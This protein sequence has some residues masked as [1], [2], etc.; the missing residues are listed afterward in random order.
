MRD[1]I[2]GFCHSRTS[3]CSP[4]FS[5]KEQNCISLKIIQVF[6]ANFKITFKPM[7]IIWYQKSKLCTW[8][9]VESPLFYA[10]GAS[11]SLL[12]LFEMRRVWCVSWRSFH[13]ARFTLGSWH[14][15]RRGGRGWC[16]GFPFFA[17]LNRQKWRMD[18]C[19]SQYLT[20]WRFFFQLCL[21]LHEVLL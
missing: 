21:G 14:R 16:R 6:C 1:Q 12:A 5:W 3:A 13:R 18:F 20:C 9:V 17:D 7:K 10:V 4:G 2:W 19:L 15:R 8:E 11:G